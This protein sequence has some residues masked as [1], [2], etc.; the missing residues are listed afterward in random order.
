M[1]VSAPAQDDYTIA[2]AYY[3]KKSDSASAAAIQKAVNEAVEAYKLWQSRI[4]RDINPSELISRIMQAGARRVAVTAPAYT[5]VQAGHI[6]KCTTA[7]I[8]YGGLED[9]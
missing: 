9:D 7:D 8:T 3:I 4:G 5:A 1:I 2:L 6:A